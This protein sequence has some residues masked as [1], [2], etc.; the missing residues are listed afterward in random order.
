MKIPRAAPS[1][2]DDTM[3]AYV[4]MPDLSAT[5]IKVPVGT[6]PNLDLLPGRIYDEDEGSL[7]PARRW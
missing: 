3:V 1:A 2:D 4:H 6:D 5:E 7:F